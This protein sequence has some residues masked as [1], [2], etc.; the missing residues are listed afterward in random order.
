MENASKAL[1]IAGGILI[2]ILIMTIGIVLFTN[3]RR[4]EI[5]YNQRLE[6]SEIQKFNA[7]FT[8][9]EGR[10]DITP[11]EIVTVINFAKNYEEKMGES[12]SVTIVSTTLNEDSEQQDLIDFIKECCQENNELKRYKVGEIK[13]AENGIVNSITFTK[14]N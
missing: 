9:Y 1:L 3:Y 4:L 14:I 11:Q 2:A 13:Y 10:T 8:K 5:S 7:N 6:T 12:V